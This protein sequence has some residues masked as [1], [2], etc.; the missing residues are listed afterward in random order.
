VREIAQSYTKEYPWRNNSK[1]LLNTA[2]NAAKKHNIPTK[3]FPKSPRW[4]STQLRELAPALRAEG[5][6]VEQLEHERI[7]RPWLVYSLN[8]HDGPSS[9]NNSSAAKATPSASQTSV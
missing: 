9:D 8:E 4:A 6:I 2:N 5:V 3:T 1:E 7:G